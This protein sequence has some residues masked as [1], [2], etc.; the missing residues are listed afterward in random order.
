MVSIYLVDAGSNRKMHSPIICS[1]SLARKHSS[2]YFPRLLSQCGLSAAGKSVYLCRSQRGACEIIEYSK[3]TVD[4]P[5][6]LS[7]GPDTGVG[8]TLQENLSPS[9]TT[10]ERSDLLK[11]A[12]GTLPLDLYRLLCDLVLEQPRGI[13]PPS[14]DELCIGF[15][16]IHNLLLDFLMYRS[17]HRA[18]KPRAHVDTFGAQAECC[19]KTLAV[20]KASRGD[21]RD[22]KRLPRSTQEDKVRYISFAHMA[23]ALK[24]VDREEVDAQLDSRLRMLD[25]SAFM[26]NYASSCFE[27]F[28]DRARTVAGC[29]NDLDT[30]ID[31]GLRVTFVVGRYDCRKEGY[32]DGEWL[33]CHGTASLNLFAERG[34]VG[35]GKACEL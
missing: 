12:S 21:E 20:G 25:G 23:G 33:V 4:E 30:F 5:N 19:G 9:L 8:I 28:Y 32:V 15:L 22:I 6:N 29:L 11:F 16:R 27:L 10:H 18:H 1:C 17:F 24:A 14:H 3:F 26:Q 2:K 7:G 13:S 34:R 31:D 35:L